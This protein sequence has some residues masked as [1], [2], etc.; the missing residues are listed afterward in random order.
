MAGEAAADA[1]AESEKGTGEESQDGAI[2]YEAI[3]KKE[4]WQ[5]KEEL[6]DKYDAARYVGAEEF[7]KRKPLFDTIKDLKKQNK[8]LAK[9]VD[10]VVSFTQKNAELA[11][12]RAI[13][14]LQAQKKE[15]IKVG[16]E[17]AVEAIDK[18]L[19]EHKAAVVAAARAKPENKV[20]EEIIAWTEANQWFN[21]DIE[22]QD[23]A[24]AY[25]ASYAKRNPK[26]TM[27]EALEETAKATKRAFPDSKY[28]KTR[29]SDPPAVETH[30][31]EKGGGGNG[32]ANK[33][34]TM[35]R[36]SDEARLTY[37][38]Y[39]QK[40]GPDGKSMMTHDQF[41]QKMEEIGDLK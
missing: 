27:E 33:K 10:G 30:G 25:C 32:S 3:A 39:V 40:K 34:Y 35:N 28:F 37:K 7:V 36:L 14:E 9:T 15:A 11:A 4:G 20:P 24:T 12:K 19:D 1:G 29:R 6:G 21:E 31:E 18:S 22:M 13:A 41:F 17:A 8:E 26:K 38:A 2:D 16:D 5:S 23:F